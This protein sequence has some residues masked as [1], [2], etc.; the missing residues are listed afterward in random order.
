MDRG[1]TSLADIVHDLNNR[2]T[3]I[4]GYSE[5]AL[6]DIHDAKAL[7]DDIQEI[8]SA[9]RKAASLTSQLLGPSRRAV[10]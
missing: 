1:P 9:A 5:L 4:Q 2:L 7:A 10:P 6:E 3:T 8:Q